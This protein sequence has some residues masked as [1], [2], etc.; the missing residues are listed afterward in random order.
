MDKKIIPQCEPWYDN[1]E[2]SYL[3]RVMDSGYITESAL[4]REFEERV[5]KFT[6]AKH[7]IA[8]ANGSVALSA[9]LLAVGVKPGDEVIVP[10][11]TFIATATSALMIGAVPIFCGVDPKTF[12]LDAKKAELLIT[13]KTRCIIPVHLFGIAADMDAINSLA[14]KH[15]LSIVEDAAQGMGVHFRGKHVG[16]LGDIGMISFHANKTGSTGEGGMLLTDDAALAGRCR[17][18]KNQGREKKGIFIHES[19]GFNFSYTELQAA[20]G[21]GQM[22]KLKEILERKKSIYN[23]YHNHLKGI[24][25]ITFP[26]IP[27]HTQPVYWFTNILVPDPE[28]LSSFLQERGI[29]TRRFFYPLHLQPCFMGQWKPAG[30]VNYSRYDQ[31]IGPLF[32][33]SVPENKESES[34]YDHGLSLPS[35]A[36]LSEKDQMFIIDAIKGFFQK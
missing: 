35:S 23:I 17:R 25:Q 21:L 34:A 2:W 11:M 7:A 9:A 12:C 14:K 4:T 20:L 28:K 31:G 32:S 18:I 30:N 16:T 8:M 29:Q 22:D 36:T 1:T 5:A 26:E 13:K 27:P 33:D 3:K 19:I 10:D 15:S 6:G 24:K